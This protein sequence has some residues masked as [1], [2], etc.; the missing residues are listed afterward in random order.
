MINTTRVPLSVKKIKN[1]QYMKKI[2]KSAS[3]KTDL[4]FIFLEDYLS[5]N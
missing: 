3:E 5:F 1:Y 4:D 2:K